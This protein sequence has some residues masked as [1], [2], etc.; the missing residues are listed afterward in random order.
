MAKE[1]EIGKVT[2][3]FEKA[4]VAVIE[5][6]SKLS[7]GD[8]I[9]IKGHTTDFTQKVDSMQV[10]HKDLKSAKKGDFIGLKVRERVRLNDKVSLVKD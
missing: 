5:L 4:E 10:E 2:H 3:Y 8:S 6:S 9:Q 7:V 1:K